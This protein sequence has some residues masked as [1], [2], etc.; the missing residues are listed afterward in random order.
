MGWPPAFLSPSL[1]SASPSSSPAPPRRSRRTEQ[2][3][4]LGRLAVMSWPGILGRQGGVRAK[5]GQIR[6]RVVQQGRVKERQRRVKEGQRRVKE[7]Q[8]RVKEGQ[9]RVIEG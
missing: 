5:E 2:W 9:R 1:W 8:R 6:V 4:L 3:C 7:R